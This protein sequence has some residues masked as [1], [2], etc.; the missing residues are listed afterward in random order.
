MG[1]YDTVKCE[2]AL[3]LP[4]ELS[5]FDVKW[6]EVEFQTQFSGWP[7]MEE[8]EIT[9]DGQLYRWKRESFLDDNKELERS[10]FSGEIPFY[11]LLERKDLDHFIQ[12]KALFWKGDLR[13]LT[14]DEYDKHDNEARLASKKQIMDQIKK[15]EKRKK[16]WWYKPYSIYSE[17]VRSIFAVIKWILLWKWKVLDKI[18]RW[19]T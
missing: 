2:Y 18:E 10:N 6:E 9:E 19:I 4:E 5:K 16:K 11:T 12:F 1:M 15:M 14:V 13:E 7:A 3:P 8:Y 17:I